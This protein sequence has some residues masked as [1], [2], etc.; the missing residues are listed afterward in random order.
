VAAQP[1]LVP[2]ST[3][4]HEAWRVD[5][6][7][8]VEQASAGSLGQAYD[9]PWPSGQSEKAPPTPSPQVAEKRDSGLA[10]ALANLYTRASRA[11]R[12]Q[13]DLRA[14]MCG[15]AGIKERN[16]AGKKMTKGQFVTAVAEKS[17]L[18]K[19]QVNTA[20]EA[21]HKIVARELGKKG[22][23]EVT[24]PG[25]VKLSVVSKPA[26]PQHEGLNPF[27][28]QMM[29][30]KAKPARKVVKIRPIKALKDAV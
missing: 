3:R 14:S 15:A 18:S 8:A 4:R 21:I 9:R 1:L 23:G 19:K 30:Y 26:V 10:V 24:L 11:G 25:L 20:L 17:G 16:M 6:G 13:T 29:T 2:R 27:T 22:P 7:A 12:W 28:K 5:A